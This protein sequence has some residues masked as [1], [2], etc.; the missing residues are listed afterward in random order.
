MTL[1]N[2]PKAVLSPLA[3]NDLKKL[4]GNARRQ[5]IVAI[6][7]L[8]VDLRPSNTKRLT[9]EGEAREVRRLRLEKWRII[10]LVFEERPIILGIRKRPPYGY[11]DI[12]HLVQ[13]VD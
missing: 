12:Q 2:K 10:Y 5:V 13:E 3:Y 6:D 1:K 8:E 9:I 7:G 4:P 11:D